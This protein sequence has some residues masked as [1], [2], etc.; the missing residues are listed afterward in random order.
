MSKSKNVSLNIALLGVFS[1]IVTVLQ[2]LSYLIKIGPF[3]LSLVLIPIVLGA[4]IYGPK[5]GAILGGV[6]GAVTVI[7]SITGIDS[8]G[9]IL[10]NSSPVLTILLCLIKGTA[11]GYVAGIVGNYAKIKNRYLSTVLAAVCAP[12]VNTGIFIAA[13]YLFFKETLYA[14]S[15]DSNVFYYTITTLVG[16]NFLIEFS[17]NAIFSPIIYRIIYALKRSIS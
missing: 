10:F 5:F 3:N 8:G 13:M 7:G 12:V 1:A 11:A 4:V 6:F 16:I 17:V 9:Y 2:S 15:G 14:W